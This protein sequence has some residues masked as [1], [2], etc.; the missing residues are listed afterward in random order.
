MQD[1]ATIVKATDALKKDHR[2]I[3][4]VL[5][6]LEKINADPASAQCETWKSVLDF[7]R[8]FAD[9]SHH[10]KEEK[11]LF[12]ALQER[13]VPRD[14]GP[15]GCM[16][17][18]HEEGRSYVR[19]MFDALDQWE[20]GG[21]NFQAQ[22]EENAGAYLRLLPGHILKE[23]EILFEMAEEAL[24][25]EDQKG[26]LRK[27]EEYEAEELGAGFQEKY[28]RLAEELERSAGNK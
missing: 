28:I 6:V 26:L 4:K 16:L 19:A 18:E 23:D 7:I 22:L 5:G 1:N 2:I 8:N 17:A 11:V 3:E 9:R 24:G 27:F 15:I 25:P 10:L 20:K 13:G 14:G 12:P 21:G